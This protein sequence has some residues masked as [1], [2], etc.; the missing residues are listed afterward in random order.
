MC[1]QDNPLNPGKGGPCVCS[2]HSTA[3]K[4]GCEKG[5]V[6]KGLAGQCAHKEGQ[7]GAASQPLGVAARAACCPRS[8]STQPAPEPAAHALLPLASC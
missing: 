5:R 3:G 8:L 6:Q 7:L 4:R 1:A 2:S